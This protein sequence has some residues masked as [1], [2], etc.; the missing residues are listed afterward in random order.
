[1][2][3]ETLSFRLESKKRKALDALA[4]TLGR[5]R[6]EVINEAIDAY[7]SLHRWQLEHIREGLRQADAGEFATETEMKATFR[8]S[9]LP[10]VGS[11]HTRRCPAA[12]PFLTFFVNLTPCGNV[13]LSE[14]S[15]GPFR[16]LG[17]E[18]LWIQTRRH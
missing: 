6:N 18:T 11:F 2:N 7:L 8:P 1:M 14:L 16:T 13:R 3:Q 12:T 17:K 15:A 4:F 5:G 10:L 9:E